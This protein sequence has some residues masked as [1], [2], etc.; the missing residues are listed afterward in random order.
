MA[1]ISELDLQN[2]RHLISGYDTTHCKMKEYA[3]MAE[4]TKVLS[5]LGQ[6]N[7]KLNHISET[8]EG[9]DK[10]M[11]TN[12]RVLA[13]AQLTTNDKLEEINEN[14]ENLSF[15]TGVLEAGVGMNAKRIENLK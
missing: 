9:M 5:M 6:M 1:N 10:R 7:Q 2:L 15:K 3:E 12:F 8:L 4:D 14:I 13:E 11:N